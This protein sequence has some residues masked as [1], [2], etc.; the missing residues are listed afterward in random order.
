[1][2]VKDCG[3]RQVYGRAAFGVVVKEI[4]P[5]VKTRTFYHPVKMYW[6]Y[7]GLKLRASQSNVPLINCSEKEIYGASEAAGFKV[8]ASNSNT[9]QCV[10]L[11]NVTMN[12]QTLL[13]EIAVDRI[14]V[15]VKVKF[16]GRIID[17]VSAGMDPAVLTAED[18]NSFLKHAGALPICTGFE[19]DVEEGALV[20]E[21]GAVILKMSSPDCEGFV[22]LNSR[23]GMCLSCLSTCK[24]KLKN[25]TGKS[26]SHSFLSD[27]NYSNQIPLP[28]PEDDLSSPTNSQESIAS[29]IGSTS[30]EVDSDD[31]PTFT[32]TKKT[33]S[34][35]MQDP[36]KVEEIFKLVEESCPNA[37]LSKF[38]TLL[39]SQ[40]INADKAK[41]LRRW[42]PR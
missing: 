17:I 24:S 16:G 31:D 21:S 8:T 12:G 38:K 18:F 10:K 5:N 23:N 13:K 25:R 41:T 4:F 39:A 27:H 33:P 19:S 20:E 15:S 30:F 9:I 32:P 42:D 35:A 28:T 29:T 40:V 26:V 3:G 36:S 2:Y 6:G 1:M 34:P 14:D 22:N 7:V 37:D 11:S